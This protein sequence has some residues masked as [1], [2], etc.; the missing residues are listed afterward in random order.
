MSSST[1]NAIDYLYH[2]WIG[3]PIFIV[4]YGIMGGN[5]ASDQLKNVLTGMKLKVVETR[6]QLAFPGG[7]YGAST[8]GAIGGKLEEEAKSTWASEK[9]E[10]IRKG[11]NELLGAVEE[12][13]KEGQGVEGAA[14]K[15]A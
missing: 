8:Q 9:G 3:K 1:K 4:T 10:D 5:S 13:A 14:E 12:K 2:A 15:T 7:P 11:W 6:P